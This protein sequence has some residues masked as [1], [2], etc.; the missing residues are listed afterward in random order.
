MLILE[1]VY[2]RL[3]TMIDLVYADLPHLSSIVPFTPS[4]FF[5]S[6]LLTTRSRIIPAAFQLY[7]RVS[8]I[9]VTLQIIPDL[10]S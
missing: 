3:P 10:W 5:F 1:E 9:A 2:S 4:P 8:H 6:L 7:N